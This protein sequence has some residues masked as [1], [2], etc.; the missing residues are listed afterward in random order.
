MRLMTV[1]IKNLPALILAALLFSGCVMGEDGDDGK[2]GTRGETGIPGTIGEY[3]AALLPC[4]QCIDNASMQDGAVGTRNLVDQAIRTNHIKPASVRGE[5][6]ADGAI[7]NPKIVD[8]A[9]TQEK[10]AP[11]AVTGGKIA[12]EAVKA[13]DFMPGA[14]QAGN[15]ATDAVE[16][17]N[18]APDSVQSSHLADFS[19]LAGNFGT[20]SVATN[21]IANNAVD[22]WH[23]LEG[24]VNR[25]WK[26]SGNN[27]DTF[28]THN[29]WTLMDDME[30]TVDART[31]A[32]YLIM[33]NAGIYGSTSNMVTRVRLVSDGAPLNFQQLPSGHHYNVTYNSHTCDDCYHNHNHGPTTYGQYLGTVSVHWAGSLAPGDHTIQAQW[34]N[35]SGSLTQD[36]GQGD[37]TLTVIEFA[38][39]P[40]Q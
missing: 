12:A 33:L 21:N 4:D 37:R 15:I 16:A 8:Q 7:T 22:T 40:V 6:I 5:R 20:G 9:V 29:S 34:W 38:K 1:K 30:I 2:D 31:D 19:V 11:G 23:V 26:A 3:G 25:F 36:P 13:G 35:A 27:V 18:I 39:T 14:I 10:L 32:A 17:G 24:Q 28:G